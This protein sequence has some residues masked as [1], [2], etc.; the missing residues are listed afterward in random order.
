MNNLLVLQS[1]FGLVDG[2]VSAMIGVAL[3]ESA[4]LKIHH[5]THDITPYNIFE[6]SYRLFQTV[7]YWPE[8]TLQTMEPCLLLRN[9]LVLWLFG[10]FLKSKIVERIPNIPIPSMV[11]MSMH[12]QEPNWLVATSLLKK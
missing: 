11:V 6:G 10:K 1:D 2:A 9:T 7:N 3:E 4:T 5:L 8:G 12:T